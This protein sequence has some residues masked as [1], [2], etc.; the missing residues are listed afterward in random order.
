MPVTC[1]FA[2]PENVVAAH[3]AATHW[4]L[5]NAFFIFMFRPFLS[6]AFSHVENHMNTC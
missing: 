4:R 2:V 6:N 3:S 1:A 5:K